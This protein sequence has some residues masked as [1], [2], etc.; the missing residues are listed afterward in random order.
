[1][2]PNRTLPIC[3]LALAGGSIHASGPVQWFSVPAPGLEA[4]WRADAGLL[5]EDESPSQLVD[6]A[7]RGGSYTGLE[8]NYQTDRAARGELLWR[9]PSVQFGLETAVEALP[10]LVFGLDA[11][12]QHPQTTL[13]HADGARWKLY[14]PQGGLRIGA[15]VDLLRSWRKS[16]DWRWVV[17]G[18]MPVFSRTRE[19]ELRSGLIFSRKL[20]AD[21]SWTTS[22]PEIP[23]RWT[24]P[25][26]SIAVEDTVWWRT[27]RSRWSARLGGAPSRNLSIQA[28][29]GRRRLEDPGPLADKRGRHRPSWRSWGDGEFAG[30]QAALTTGPVVWDL[31]ARGEQGSQ[32]QFFDGSP[33]L[34][35]RVDSGKARSSVDYAGGSARLAAKTDWTGTVSSELEL[36]GSWMDLENAIVSGRPPDPVPAAT[37]SWSST[38]RLSGIVRIPVK[39]KWIEVAPFAGVQ[40]RI[41]D[42][43]WIPLWQ[44]LAPRADGRSWSAP[45]GVELARR[46]GM[47]GKAAYRLSGEIPT[48]GEALP[49][50]GL[51]HH[52]ELQQGF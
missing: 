44:G 2:I 42:G 30:A 35:A 32:T 17:A 23:G 3:A 6:L 29:V 48:S 31:E 38:R 20:R 9:Q 50:P 52:L 49:A 8:L 11:Q 15:G 26:D 51:R 1:M 13:S 43:G 47:A 22:N 39:T 27:D 36:S 25:I 16:Q 5:G 18:W 14:D 46:G 12:D 7:A 19:W 10:G 28:W 21:V 41:H 4:L 34:A 37:G 45:L 40:C 33:R 24:L